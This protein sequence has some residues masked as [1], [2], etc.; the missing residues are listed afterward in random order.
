MST[1]VATCYST[2][3]TKMEMGGVGFRILELYIVKILSS[4]VL[5]PG[6]SEIMLVR[7]DCIDFFYFVQTGHVSC[8]NR[9]KIPK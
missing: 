6:V 9:N 4:E 5:S 1:S 7:C 8:F 2:M 3:V